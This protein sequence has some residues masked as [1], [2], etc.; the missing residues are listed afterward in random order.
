LYHTHLSKW[1]KQRELAER[2][3]L[4]PQK[5]G[6]KPQETNP[7]AARVAQLERDN[8]RLQQRLQQAEAIIDVQK[9]ISAL[10]ENP[11]RGGNN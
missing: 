3:A 2:E 10:L 5:Q 1:R 11:L 4:A 8:E 6:R 7:L 9:K